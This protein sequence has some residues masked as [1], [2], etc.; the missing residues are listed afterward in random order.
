MV[1]L[2]LMDLLNILAIVLIAIQEPIVKLREMFAHLI[3]VKLE[4]VQQMQKIAVI[5]AM[6]TFVT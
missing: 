4:S 3:H 5:P 6:E 2:V 1:E